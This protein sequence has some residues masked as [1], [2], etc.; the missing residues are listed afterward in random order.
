MYA[1]GRCCARGRARSGADAFCGGSVQQLKGGFPSTYQH[2]PEPS[3]TY[4]HLPSAFLRP[5]KGGSNEV[6]FAAL[7]RKSCDIHNIFMY[8][9][10]HVFYLEDTPNALS[11]R[12]RMRKFIRGEI[13]PAP[14]EGMGDE[15]GLCAKGSSIYA[16]FL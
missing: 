2:L 4:Q 8:N 12:G 5:W 11:E 7:R 9:M 3:R 6:E 1:D 10:L 13:L 15:I 16:D 14:G